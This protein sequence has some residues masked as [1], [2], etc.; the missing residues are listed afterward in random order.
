[1]PWTEITRPD[2]VGWNLQLALLQTM[3]A[4]PQIELSA[5]QTTQQALYSLPEDGVSS[6]PSH[7]SGDAG[8][9][10][11]IEKRPCH[12]QMHGSQSQ[13]SDDRLDLS[14]SK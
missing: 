14:Q 11:K 7:G 1:M 4:P 12:H 9:L 10:Q 2:Y 8:D 3:D 6:E 5:G 13:Q